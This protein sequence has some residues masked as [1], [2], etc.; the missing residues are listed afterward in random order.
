MDE[1]SSSPTLAANPPQRVT[2]E[3][4]L[5]RLVAEHGETRFV[6][7]R[8]ALGE[9]AGEW[10]DPG[11]GSD[12]GPGDG[13]ICDVETQ[14]RYPSLLSRTCVWRCESSSLLASPAPSCACAL[15]CVS[16]SSRH[17]HAVHLA[18]LIVLA[19]AGR[20]RINGLGKYFQRV[21][22]RA[23]K[24]EVLVCRRKHLRVGGDGTF[25]NMSI[26]RYT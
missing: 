8:P 12:C 24:V 5:R 15:A 17:I 16:L 7:R 11:A 9:H 4:L 25:F 19:G 18:L 23:V 21:G 22:K 20:K 14:K 2:A 6:F 3:G 1:V 10:R 26:L 13:P